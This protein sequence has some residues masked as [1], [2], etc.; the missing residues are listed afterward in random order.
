MY[1][2]Q[3]HKADIDSKAKNSVENGKNIFLGTN[4]LEQMDGPTKKHEKS[5]TAEPQVLWGTDFSEVTV[6]W[7]TRGQLCG[8]M[9]DDLGCT[10]KYE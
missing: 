8:T 7:K 10:L 6:G 1:W 3:A 9:T 5:M 2:S 4:Q